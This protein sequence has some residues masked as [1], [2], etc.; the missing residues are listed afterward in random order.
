ML[1][2]KLSRIS[3]KMTDLQE[4]EDMKRRKKESVKA[5]KK[6]IEGLETRTRKMSRKALTFD[7]PTPNSNPS[8]NSDR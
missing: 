4:F 7:T 1:P 6:G 3:F 5:A 2:Q 8:S